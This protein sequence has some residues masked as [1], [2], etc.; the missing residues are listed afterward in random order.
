MKKWYL[1]IFLIL[2][3]VL[4]CNPLKD[5]SKQNLKEKLS[6]LDTST[7]IIKR[8]GEVIILPSPRTP[9]KVFRDTI[10]EYRTKKG[11]TVSTR[12]NDKGEI[13]NQIVICPD[14]E[15]TKQTN[16]KAEYQYKQRLVEKEL[17]IEAINA[18]GKWTAITF[19]PIGFFFA[20]AFYFKSR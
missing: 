8:Q 19:I 4:G 11:A 9:N 12:Y 14:S 13:D 3:S 1:I 17:N 6:Y 2:V 18:I 5:V 16:I 10:V 7:E 20:V 15:E